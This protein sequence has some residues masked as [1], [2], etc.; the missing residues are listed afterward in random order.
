MHTPRLHVPRPVLPRRG[1][2]GFTLVVVAALAAVLLG[3]IV[4]PGRG[5]QAA[6]E[7]DA[8]VEIVLTK[9]IPLE[10][11]LKAVGNVTEIPLYWDPTTRGIKGKELVGARNLKAPR[12][13]LFNLVRALL[14]FYELV[15]IPVGPEG[16]QVYLVMDARQT[17]SIVKL[18]PTFVELN[19][20][21]LEF[22]ENQDGL[23]VTTTLRVENMSSLRDARNALNRIVTGQNI[24]NVTEV[25]AARAFVVTDFAPNVVAI[26]RLLREMDVQPEGRQVTSAYIKLEWATADESEPVLTDIFTGRE[27]VSQR[28][29]PQQGQSGNI[30][31]DPEPRIMSDFR[32]NQIIVYATQDDIAEIRDVVAQLDVPVYLPNTWVNVIQLKNLRAAET[33][34]VLQAL[35]EA[36]T[37]FGTT[38]Q[39]GGGTGRSRTPTG[40]SQPGGRSGQPS[41]RPDEQEKP[42]VVADEAS[43]SLLISASPRQFEQLKH[44]IE[45][46]DIKKPQVLIEAALLELTLDDAYN[47]QIELGMGDDNG[48]V[49]DNAASGFGFTTFGLAEF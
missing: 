34:E 23:F 10:D 25:P 3:S 29:R 15:M 4:L 27:R 42:A 47:L 6:P 7:D 5:T 39:G 2:M 41:L 38:N 19:E 26:Y 16:Y 18:K 49:N 40:R 17:A 1:T 43:N 30:E 37:F 9:A 33:A 21:N 8:M 14:T 20:D 28:V 35:I 11:F 12:K 32:T 24:G 22:Y 48:L 31:Q 13:E 36:S 45:S 44:I 46:I